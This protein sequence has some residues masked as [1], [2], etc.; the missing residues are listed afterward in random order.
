M[1]LIEQRSPAVRTGLTVAIVLTTG[2]GWPWHE[3]GTPG[4][5]DA[6]ALLGSSIRP[7]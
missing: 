1:A 3:D 2:D 4:G 5:I 6:L 7:C